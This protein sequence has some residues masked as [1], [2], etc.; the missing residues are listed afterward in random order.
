MP[1]SVAPQNKQCEESHRYIAHKVVAQ[2]KGKESIAW[3]IRLLR[4]AQGMNFLVPVGWKDIQFLTYTSC[5]DAIRYLEEGGG[6]YDD[7]LNRL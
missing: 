7:Y 3:E 6:S 5:V 4:D 2:L 1:T